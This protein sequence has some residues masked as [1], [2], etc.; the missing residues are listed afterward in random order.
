[1]KVREVCAAVDDFAPPSLAYEWDRAGLQIGD[2]EAEVSHVLVALT[3]TRDAFDAALRAGAD[4]IVTHHPVIWDPLRAL[5]TDDPYTRLCLDVA[6]R[7]IAC[8]AAHTALDVAPGGVSAVLARQLGLLDV[9]PL[10]PA[11][12]ARQVKLVTF[13]PASHVAQVREAVC[14]AGAGVIGAYTFC[15]FSAAGTGT[16]RPGEDAQPF[17]GER[18]RLNEEP[19]LRFEVL[20][21]KAKLETVLH[22]L[23]SA[24]PYEEPAYDVVCL[25][26]SDPAVG[27]GIRGE[28]PGPMTLD[29]FAE[30]AR[31]ALGTPYVRTMGRGGQSVQHVA[32]LG[33][34]GGGEIAR[35]PRDIDVYLT[36]DIGYH[37]AVLAE[38]RGI[39]LVDAGH[40]GTEKGIVQALAG[41]LAAK[42]MPVRVS[43][44]EES[45]RFTV[46]QGSV[47]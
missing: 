26:N 7:G 34:S 41:H 40:A 45:E 3:L 47:S 11:P 16:F 44:W 24:H 42:L 13:V 33:G 29:A 9:R 6:H 19:E 37:D 2:P 32:A 35:L 38:A 25:E 23:R 28:L 27:L 21:P 5:R 17:A 46:S 20:T 36:G 14:Q 4:M 10:F 30:H 18:L 8:Y 43:D 39:A 22:A 1:M 31:V 12:Q 15:S